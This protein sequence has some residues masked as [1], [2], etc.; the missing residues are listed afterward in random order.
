MP[1]SFPFQPEHSDGIKV[2]ASLDYLL[3]EGFATPLDSFHPSLDAKIGV[4]PL[5]SITVKQRDGDKLVL[6]LRSVSSLTAAQYLDFS[7]ICPGG[8]CQAMKILSD[9][10]KV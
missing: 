4:N 6:D 1:R 8:V 9:K 5:V 10:G 3:A 2:G 7:L